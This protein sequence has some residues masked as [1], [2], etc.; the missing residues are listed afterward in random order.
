MNFQELLLSITLSD[1]S[2][3]SREE[4]TLFLPLIENFKKRSIETNEKGE[5]IFEVVGEKEE[6]GVLKGGVVTAIDYLPWNDILGYRVNPSFIR[7]QVTLE[8]FAYLVLLNM[9]YEGTEEQQRT[10]RILA[11]HTQNP[12]ADRDDHSWYETVETVETE[13]GRLMAGGIHQ[14]ET[15]FM[16]CLRPSQ[17]IEERKVRLFEQKK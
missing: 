11:L 3:I 12:N 1:C 14:R 2:E 4:L 6:I 13:K 7:K 8:Y 17:L 10:K 16:L 15:F 5:L 9:T